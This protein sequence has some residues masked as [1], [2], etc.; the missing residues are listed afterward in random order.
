MPC[1]EKTYWFPRKRYGWGWGFPSSWQ[2]WVTLLL[3][4]VALALA[5]IFFNPADH[6]VAFFASTLSASVLLLIICFWKGEPPA[7]RW[8]K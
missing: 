2:G 6:P 4:L 5:S 7:W 8:G 3:Y 1:E